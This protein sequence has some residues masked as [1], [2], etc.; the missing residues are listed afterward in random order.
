M[1]DEA[2]CE[3]GSRVLK[4][5]ALLVVGVLVLHPTIVSAQY[6]VGPYVMAGGGSRMTGGSYVV[7][8]TAGQAAP[9]DVSS[10]GS[11]ITH[12]GFW[13]AVGGG[14][15]GPMVLAIELLNA[16]TGRLSWNAVAGA[17]HYD[18]Y[19]SSTAYLAASGTPWQTVAAPTTH[20][21]FTGGIGNTATNYFFRGKARNTTQTSPASN[22]VGEFD[23][24]ISTA[25]T[26]KT[27]PAEDPR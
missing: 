25:V 4:L 16:T 18:L 24:G 2:A 5:L 3:H 26:A 20:R 15:L 1:R 22:I 11:T 12:H 10:G 19:R 14:A 23:F 7:T 27:I 6:V 8:S 13:H 21:D 17:T 9:I